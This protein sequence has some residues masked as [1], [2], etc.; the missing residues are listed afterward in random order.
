MLVPTS[1]R[2]SR[3][4]PTP[5]SSGPKQLLSHKVTGPF[6]CFLPGLELHGSGFE[7]RLSVAAL[8]KAVHIC[9]PYFLHL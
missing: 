8:G 7:C 9:D 1:P 4:L 2:A 6:S 5:T 3:L